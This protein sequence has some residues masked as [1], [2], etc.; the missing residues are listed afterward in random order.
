MDFQSTFEENLLI[1]HLK[2]NAGWICPLTNSFQKKCI[3]SCWVDKFVFVVEKIQNSGFFSY[4][5]KK[6]TH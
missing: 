2:R 6:K 3:I 5:E 1:F 4:L